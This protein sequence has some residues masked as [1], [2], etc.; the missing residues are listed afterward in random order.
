MVGAVPWA[1]CA[2][3]WVVF[4]VARYFLWVFNRPGWG[5]Q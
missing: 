5:F 1:F 2:A 4:A 3:V